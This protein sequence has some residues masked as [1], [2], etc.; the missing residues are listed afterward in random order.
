MTAT[1]KEETVK[2]ALFQDD[3]RYKAPLFVGVNGKS[4]L[5]ERGKEVEIPKSVYEVIIN[6]MNQTRAKEKAMEGARE[7][8]LIQG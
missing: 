1:K 3:D 5:I 6:S 2:F 7:V 8:E 4:Y